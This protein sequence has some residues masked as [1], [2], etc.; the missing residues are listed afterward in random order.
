MKNNSI[1]KNILF[2]TAMFGLLPATL[3]LSHSNVTLANETEIISSDFIF[4]NGYIEAP[5]SEEVPIVGIPGS[6]NGLQLYG[7]S[8]YYNAYELGLLPALRNQGSG[9]TCWAFANTGAV[10]A[11]LILDGA[12]TD[13]DLSELHVAYFTSHMYDDPTNCH[14]ADT[15]SC[16][17]NWI[18]NGGCSE[19]AYR[20][21][22]EGIGLIPESDM[23]YRY[24]NEL[25][26]FSVSDDYAYGHNAYRIKEA[27]LID[28]NDTEGIKYAIK[29]H[30]G[31]AASIYIKDRDNTYFNN[32]YNAYCYP[33]SDANHAVMLVGWDDNFPKE[34]FNSACRP[35]SNGAWLVRNSWGGDGYS[36]YGYFW[37][38]YEDAGLLSRDKVVAYDADNTTFNRTYAYFRN[39]HP[40]A[41]ATVPAGT[42]V[43]TSFTAVT[44]E[45]IKAIGFETN[46]AE[47]TAYVTVTAGDQSAT[48]SINTSFAGFYTIDLNNELVV[49]PGTEVTVELSFSKEVRLFIENPK[50][51]EYSTLYMSNT[52]TRGFDMIYSYG[53]SN[54][55]NYD[56]MIMMY[57]SNIELIDISLNLS[58]LDMNVGERQTLTAITTPAV[59]SDN[60]F[61]WSSSNS[62]VA[63][64]DSNGQVSAKHVGK[65]IITVTASN[66]KSASCA[67]TVTFEPL[68][69]K[70]EDGKI[71]LY[72]MYNPNSGEHFWTGSGQEVADL[73]NAGWDFEGDGWWAPLEGQPLYRLYNPNA[74]DHH[75]TMDASERDNLVNAGWRYEGDAWNSAPEGEGYPLYRL[76]NP[77]AQAGS[78][79]LTAS[80]EERDNLCNAGWTYEGV[81]CRG[82]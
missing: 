51:E 34:N 45:V 46:S 55:V 53:L 1:L 7:A 60:N 9:E 28:I 44:G 68:P 38:S 57:T 77:N 75:Y 67:V 78:H 47:F 79:H 64:V 11:D 39:F 20:A 54:H 5:D 43:R 80:A 26:G 8:P 24:G 56:P 35:S 31:V 3:V 27:Y 50:A 15:V 72:R 16:N 22:M 29:T 42:I 63:S 14:D 6:A 12:G 2:K 48:G 81:S 73:V 59:V 18:A 36:R 40:G 71:L 52:C 66:G 4:G 69:D 17:S 74:G 58:S 37:L 10:E 32:N 13:I 76:Y 65:A 23:P 49:S 82:L 25:N 62:Y 33:Y 19:L 70:I 30:G 41:R 21:W 61:T